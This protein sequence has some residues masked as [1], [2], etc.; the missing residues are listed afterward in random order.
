MKKIGLWVLSVVCGI[1][2]LSGLCVLPSSWG[3]LFFA[4]P[5][6]LFNPLFRNVLSKHNIKF[7]KSIIA[8]A[9]I[10]PIITTGVA[11]A[12]SP[13][14]PVRT[15][16]ATVSSATSAVAS[17]MPAVSKAL[18][19]SLPTSSASASSQVAVVPAV[20]SGA[21]LKVH[22]IDV[23][24]G[25]SEFLELPNG[26]CMLIDAGIPE[27]GPTVVS[28]VKGLGHTKI[29]YLIATH[30]HADH[31]GGMTDVI[32][33]F[34]V[35]Q[36]YMPRTS[37][38]DTPTTATYKDLLS[39]VQSKNIP[40][41]T[42]KAGVTILKTGNL[43][44][45]L[46]A[47]CGTGYG[48]LNQYSAVM[49]LQY[50]DNKFLFTGDA[51][52]AS[53]GQITSNVKAD[54]LK[55]GHHGSNTATT[56]VFLN[57]VSPKYAVIE[58]GAGNSYGHPTAATLTKLQKAGVTIYRTDKDGTII[59]A[60]DSHT[61]TVDKKSSSVQ[62]QAPPQQVSSST[63]GKT[64]AGIAAGYVAGKAAGGS[65]KKPSSSAVSTK[66]PVPVGGGSGTTVYI[67]NTG[68]KYHTDG[69]RYLKKSKIAISL[70]DAKAE[71]Y[72]PCKVCNPP[73]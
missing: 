32:N 24:Q 4:I 8:A 51:G 60:S 73:T 19:P 21:K 58:V 63:A 14:I 70:S 2:A 34:A 42:A 55:V 15:S 30:P 72:E 57:K 62:S 59:F 43:S 66:A 18:S 29:D 35:S 36:M 49:M 3:M 40:V 28:Y 37:S 68:K 11:A 69:C 31:I 39:A 67:T 23:G 52:A 53:E 71:G 7:R 65:T 25:D 10:L 20:S 41:H 5:T 38:A 27:K 9:A 45:D 6:V 54:V 1:L 17:S 46:I 26:Q 12:T 61:I 33:T 13:P 44:L 56:Q 16:T 47:P 50:G 22:Y 64:A 48:D